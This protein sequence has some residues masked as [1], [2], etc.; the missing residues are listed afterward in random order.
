[1]SKMQIDD[2]NVKNKRQANI[3]CA[4]DDVF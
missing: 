3:A 1:M 2:L 4:D